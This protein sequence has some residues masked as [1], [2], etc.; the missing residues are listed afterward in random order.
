MAQLRPSR[1]RFR[2]LRRYR[3]PGAPSVPIA[4]FASSRGTLSCELRDR[5]VPAADRLGHPRHPPRRES[6]ADQRLRAREI[7]DQLEALAAGGGVGDHP[8]ANFV[9]AVAGARKRIG[10]K[11][12]ESR[13]FAV[14]EMLDAGVIEFL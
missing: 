11:R 6:S 4:T 13:I 1:P 10:E 2:G 3:L 5:T 12:G 7:V 14:L 9:R 8:V